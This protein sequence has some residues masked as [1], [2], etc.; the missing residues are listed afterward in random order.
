MVNGLKTMKENDKCQIIF[1]LANVSLVNSKLLLQ[2]HGEAK[3]A[4]FKLW[5]TKKLSTRFKLKK[6]KMPT[7]ESFGNP[8]VINR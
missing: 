3:Q 1:T 7:F 5:K 4:F 8:F 2:L 6:L